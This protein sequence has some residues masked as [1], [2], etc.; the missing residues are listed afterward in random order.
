MYKKNFDYI[1]FTLE[2]ICSVKS[3]YN[4]PKDKYKYLTKEISKY[5][6]ILNDYQILNL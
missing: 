5:G 1:N 2:L 3:F 6:D 4:Y